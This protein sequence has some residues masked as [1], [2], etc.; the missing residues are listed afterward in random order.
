MQGAV[1][2]CERCGGVAGRKVHLVVS[3]DKTSANL[4]SV[5]DLVDNQHVFMVVDDSALAFLPYR[6]LLDQDVPMIGGGFD[7][8]YYGAPGNEK[9]ISGSAT[10]LLRPGSRRP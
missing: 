1:R 4:Q 7:G 6:W 9:I 2:T 5:Q 8:N 3:D 10:G